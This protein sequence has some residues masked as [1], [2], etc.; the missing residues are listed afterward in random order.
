MGLAASMSHM[1]LTPSSG[2]IRVLPMTGTGI[3]PILYVAQ[4]SKQIAGS[5]IISGGCL[6]NDL[7]ELMSRFCLHMALNRPRIFRLPSC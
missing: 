3:C 4:I 2:T 7:S 1:A 5:C 6:M